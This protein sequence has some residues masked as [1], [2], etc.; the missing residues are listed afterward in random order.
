MFE[1]VTDELQA[2]DVSVSRV[3]PCYIFLKTNLS[4]NF[5]E[6][7][8]S[9]QLRLDLLAALCKRFDTLVQNDVFKI[10]TFL[11]CN[12]GMKSFEIDKHNEIRKLIKSKLNNIMTSL[13]SIETNTAKNQSENEKERGNNYICFQHAELNEPDELDNTI[14]E[15]LSALKVNKLN[16]TL[17]FWKTNESRWPFLAK[18]AKKHLGVPASSA[19]VE[20]IFSIGGHILSNKR[21]RSGIQLFSDEVFLKLNE[22][23]LL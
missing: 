22:H 6:N 1:F 9:K 2:N 10:A 19:A 21:R 18:L 3:Y 23:L 12:F 16:C 20:R 7:K 8:Y 11:D 5:D 4:K 17:E 13:K 14:D 15:Y